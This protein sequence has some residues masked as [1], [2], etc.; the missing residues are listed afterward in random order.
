MLA[1]TSPRRRELLARLGIA[2]EVRLVHVEESW[3]QGESPWSYARRTASEKLA[4]ARVCWPDRAVVAADTVVE[5]EEVALGKPASP[6]EAVSMLQALRGRMHQVHTAV[7]ASSRGR[8]RMVV[9]TTLVEMRAYTDDE[10]TQYI[11]TREPFDK[12]GGYAIQDP[13]FA[14]VRH[15]RGLYSNVVGLP[16]GPTARLLMAL[17]LS[18]GPYTA[19]DID[20]LK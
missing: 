14:P 10:I 13:Y 5:L 19:A 8:S 12:A 6:Q 1:S 18:L 11:A 7:A 4:A 3:V 15:I 2:F 16:L 20:L 9:C 17:G